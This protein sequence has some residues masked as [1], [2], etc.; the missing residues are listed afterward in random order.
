M[1][2]KVPRFARDDIRALLPRSTAIGSARAAFR[3]AIRI[4]P[5]AIK[6]NPATAPAIEVG[7]VAVTP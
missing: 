2:G 7:S 6:V 4:A 5:T 1:A 3:V